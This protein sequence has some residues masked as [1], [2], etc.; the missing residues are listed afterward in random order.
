MS[1]LKLAFTLLI[2]IVL[3]S[4][5]Q[6]YGQAPAGVAPGGE[7]GDMTQG[8]GDDMGGRGMGGFGRGETLTVD[9]NN[10]D[11][12]KQIFDGK[13]LNN[14][15]GAKEVWS[16]VDGA[17]VG[18]STRENPAGTTFIIYEG[19]DVSDFEIKLEFKIEGGNGG[20]QYRSQKMEF[21]ADRGGFAGARGGDAGGGNA[22]GGRGTMPARGGDAEGGNAAG[23][24]GTMQG[25][26]GD[27]EDGGR[28]D[29]GGGFVMVT[30]YS[31]WN[32]GGYQ[33]DMAGTMT[34]QLFENSRNSRGIATNVGQVLSL[35]P[36]NQKKL[37]ATLGT[38][39]EIL[40][41]FKDGD[42]NTCHVI[43]KGNML[44]HIINGRLASMTI[45]NDPE[46]LKT[47]GTFAL[48]IEG[49]GVL[50]YRNIWLKEL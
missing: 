31:A 21:G 44:I 28:G 10:F 18:T 14:W 39:D 5:I 12:F 41:T 3:V 40:G 26:G 23:G 34:G 20:L 29:R 49:T 37:L 46:R 19:P 25:R 4:A 11:G 38:A 32:V 45:D 50:S 15:D 42:W 22:A 2:V 27:A 35:E 30:T 9:F 8:R 7:R 17:I 13:T 1:K 48:Q 47:S 24:R 16:V 33:A 6:L 43:A 36:D